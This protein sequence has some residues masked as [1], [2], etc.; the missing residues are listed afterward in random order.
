LAIGEYARN[1]PDIVRN[2]DLSKDAVTVIEKIID[3]IGYYDTDS[4]LRSSTIPGYHDEITFVFNDIVDVL[5][6]ESF[7]A[8]LRRLGFDIGD[9]DGEEWDTPGYDSYSD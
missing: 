1:N 9:F 2:V 4:Y 7:L 8:F 5:A 6:L 3:S